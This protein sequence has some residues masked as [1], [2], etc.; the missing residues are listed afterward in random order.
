MQLDAVG[1]RLSARARRD[2]VP[3]GGAG[4]V[5]NFRGRGPPAAFR[6]CERKTNTKFGRETTGQKIA[7]VWI[8]KTPLT[9]AA[10][11]EDAALAAPGH[12]SERKALAHR[13]AHSLQHGAVLQLGDAGRVRVSHHLI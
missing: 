12:S 2:P 9:C 13:L 6:V 10:G 11:A 4:K 5:G 3:V 8:V 1:A 7:N